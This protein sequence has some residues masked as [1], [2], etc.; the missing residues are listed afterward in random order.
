MFPSI[1]V[2]TETPSASL[3]IVSAAFPGIRSHLTNS[4]SVFMSA[5]ILKVLPPLSA[6]K[7]HGKPFVNYTM[8]Y[9]NIMSSVFHIFFHSSVSFEN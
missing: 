5:N 1:L 9:I 3:S 4:G 7:M 2:H 8:F 6:N